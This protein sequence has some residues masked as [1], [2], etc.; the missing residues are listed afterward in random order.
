ML[1]IVGEGNMVK[2]VAL[3]TVTPFT[4]NLIFPVDAP[5]GTEVTILVAVDNEIKAVV[6]LNL[7]T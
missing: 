3:V 5:T 4:V 7:R 2:S 1:V 6:L